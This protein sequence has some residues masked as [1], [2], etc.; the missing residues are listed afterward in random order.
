MKPAIPKTDSIAELAQFWDT[1][2]ITSFKE[3]VE[4]VKERVFERLPADALP[5]P[6]SEEERLAIRQLAQSRGVEEVALIREW[7]REKLRLV[8]RP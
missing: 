8:K 7:V 4:E 1:H 5:V 2:D 6:L 3:E